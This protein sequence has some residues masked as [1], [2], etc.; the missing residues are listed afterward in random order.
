VRNLL[1]NATLLVVGAAGV[2]VWNA[3]GVDAPGS[4]SAT[5]PPATSATTGASSPAPATGTSA[6]ETSSTTT[7]TPRSSSAA[8][9]S[10]TAAPAGNAT[11]I[12]V[13]AVGDIMVHESQLAGSYVAASGS[14]D[15]H[16]SFA[17][18]A[19]YIRAADFAVG[20]FETRTAGAARGYSGFP[21]FNTPGT[22][23]QAV[24]DAGF[25]LVG[26]AN[27]HALDQDYEGLVKTL[28]T[29][30][31]YDLPSVGNY[32]SAD[33][34]QKVFMADIRG[35]K[36]AFLAYTEILSR[37]TLP[38]DK[39]WCVS[40]LGDGSACMEQAKA[41]RAQGADI[42]IAMLHWG[43]EDQRTQSANQWTIGTR[44]L[45]NGVDVVIG[46]HP[47]V[48]QPIARLTVERGGRQSAGYLAYSLGNFLSNQTWQ[49]CDSGIV[50]YVDIV[51]DGDG[52]RVS[53]LRYLPVYVEKQPLAGQEQWRVVPVLPGVEPVTDVPLN[54]ASRQRMADVWDEMRAQVQNPASGIS[55]CSA[56]DF[57]PSAA[58]LSLG[59]AGTGG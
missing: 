8:T 45:R 5:P 52:A 36:V 3:G 15:F 24:K 7:V 25:D 28:D 47:H 55:P 14:Y 13:A 17:P 58:S 31:V 50:L 6:A 22:I 12:T 1:L 32:R 29:F 16:P 19:P 27:N 51:K 37:T 33:D 11:R 40:M 2:L 34:R 49:Y 4:P 38:A 56:A 30:A 43:E 20:N 57:S 48:V 23:V 21:L 54:A 53:G 18:I 10:T 44:L 39:P 46:S 41:A 26:T 59:S 9:T 42:V 35:V